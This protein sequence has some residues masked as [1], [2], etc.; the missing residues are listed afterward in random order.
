MHY[1]F[2]SQ[3]VYWEKVE[4]HQELKDKYLN[5]ILDDVSK[6]SK[7]YRTNSHWNCD[8]ISSYFASSQKNNKEIFD[9]Y[10]IDSVIKK[11]IE[12]CIEELQLPAPKNILIQSLW[13]NVYKKNDYQEVHDHLGP[14]YT[15]FSGIYILD[16]VGK[17]NTHFFSPG[18]VPD[19]S[20]FGHH[21]KGNHL[22]E[23]DVII[24]PASLLHY[25]SPCETNKVSV[26]FNVG[27]EY[28]LY[29]KRP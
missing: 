3:F 1:T 29:E 24:F 26:S 13:Y 6:N 18:H 16:L 7:E 10:F 2:P 5:L 20:R 21:F 14:N 25:V 27:T 9:N 15:A 28:N 11:P 4:N 19:S 23:G 12:N 22:E 8:V 17:N